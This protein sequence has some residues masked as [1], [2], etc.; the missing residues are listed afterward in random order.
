VKLSLTVL[1]PRPDV[2][3]FA[4]ASTSVLEFERVDEVRIPR[5]EQLVH[6]VFD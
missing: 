6:S 4:H 1:E 2:R 3:E 5:L